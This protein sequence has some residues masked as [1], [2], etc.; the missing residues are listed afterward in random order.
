MLQVETTDEGRPALNPSE[1]V[2]KVLEITE[3]LDYLVH[4]R[5]INW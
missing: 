3:T 1:T 5:E 4:G 2:V